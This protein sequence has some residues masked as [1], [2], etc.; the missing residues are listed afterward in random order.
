ML[1]SGREFVRTFEPTTDAE[2][3]R[4]T[5][6]GFK[7]TGRVASYVA[8]FCELSGVIRDMSANPSVTVHSCTV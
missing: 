4:Q 2:L 5:L 8:R 1:N 3:A 7:Q 6:E